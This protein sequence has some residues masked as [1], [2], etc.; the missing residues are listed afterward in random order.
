VAGESKLV[1]PAADLPIMT[2]GPNR[3]D[4]NRPA[5]FFDRDNTLIACDGFLG[6]PAQVSLISGAA[7]AVAR[8]RQLGYAT[9]IISNQSG[10]GRGLF[11]ED[12]V[13]AVNS[14]LDT[15]LAADNS[16]AVID[17]HEFCPFHP[18][19]TVEAYRQESDLR[20]PKPGM[21]LKAAR[22]LGLDLTRSW[23][24]G[25]APRDIEAGNAAGCRTILFCDPAI[26][27]STATTQP[28]NVAPEFTVDS[29]EDAMEIIE[30]DGKPP[31]PIDPPQ[32]SATQ[33]TPQ[34][35]TVQPI[36][37]PPSTARLESLAEDILRELR[38]RTERDHSDFS[39]SKLMAGIVQILA[40]AVLFYA[41]INRNDAA[42]PAS[43]LL[44]IMLQT[45]TV[46]LLI[47]GRQK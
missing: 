7:D 9:V 43:L 27:P 25:D 18:E 8:A 40:L 35:I 5:I 16:A 32:P 46:A 12:D 20:K 37:T 14:R 21:I 39:V 6:D 17:R 24:I 10:V 23:M 44:A 47:M 11:S 30:Q 41:Y 26:P 4:M 2:H 31:K 13:R 45:L 36:P 28:T 33:P 15:L 42:L 38:R 22:Q 3:S 1:D 34:P 19:A 29:L